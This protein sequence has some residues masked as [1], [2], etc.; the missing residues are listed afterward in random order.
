VFIF[1]NPALG[2]G[3][4]S[5][6]QGRVCRNFFL[7]GA[8]RGGFFLELNH[9]AGMKPTSRRDGFRLSPVYP[10]LNGNDLSEG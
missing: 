4:A 6:G 7:V 3:A 2:T 10:R 9:L 1:L 8:L 5:V